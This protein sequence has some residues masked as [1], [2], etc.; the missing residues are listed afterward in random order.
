MGLL[1]IYNEDSICSERKVSDGYA[2]NAMHIHDVYEIYMALS[3]GLKYF[4]NDRVYSLDRG[5]IMLFSNLDLH[6]ISVPADKPYERYVITFPPEALPSNAGGFDRL[7]DCFTRHDGPTS[8][9]LS[10]NEAEQRTFISLADA[11]GMYKNE[12]PYSRISQ[13]LALC[14]LLVFLNEVRLRVSQDLPAIQSSKY[15]QIRLII[16]YIDANYLQPVTLDE[17]SALCYLNK[18]YLC[19]LFRRETGF[20]IHDYIVFRRLSQA[21]L[22]LREGQQVTN[23]ARLSGFGSDT[24]FITTFKKNI[25]ITPYQYALKWGKRRS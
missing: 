2:M 8:H 3:D 7:L 19:R 20:R 15:P 18:H 13:V 4:V 11:I 25:G 6:R 17:L 9:R 21:I 14:Q 22:L 12:S 10:L 1:T 23:A 24:F 16:D 5:D